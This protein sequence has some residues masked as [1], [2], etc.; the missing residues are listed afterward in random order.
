MVK[1]LALNVFKVI[2]IQGIQVGTVNPE[3]L[4]L[5]ISADS[6]NA[7]RTISYLTLTA[8]VVVSV[9]LILYL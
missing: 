8:V 1:L 3:L 2:K 4:Q 6:Y 5:K 9:V 7:L